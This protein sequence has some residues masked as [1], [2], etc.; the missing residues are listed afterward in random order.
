MRVEDFAGHVNGITVQARGASQVI[1]ERGI[2]LIGADGIW[3]TRRRARCAGHRRPRF[4]HRTAWRTL[5][6]AERVPA[7]FREPVVHLWLGLD[8]HLVHYPVKGGRLINIVGIVHDDFDKRG[9][10]AAGEPEEILRQFRALV[11]ERDGAR[12]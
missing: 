1:D 3:S 11:L 10:S 2:A 8:A 5:V 6:P 7:E 9:W 4:A 12:A